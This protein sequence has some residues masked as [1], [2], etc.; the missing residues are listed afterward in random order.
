MGPLDPGAA[1]GGGHW[2]R[3]SSCR[4]HLVSHSGSAGPPGPDGR[5]PAAHMIGNPL[6]DEERA[7]KFAGPSPHDVACPAALR[8][9]HRWYREAEFVTANMPAQAARNFFACIIA[10]AVRLHGGRCGAGMPGRRWREMP[11]DKTA[12]R[13][14]S[15]SPTG[16]LRRKSSRRDTSGSWQDL[17]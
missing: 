5:V 8:L 12:R 4:A 15:A 13:G 10:R 1:L 9:R 2:W 11:R 17:E 7:V 3:T 14:E 16:V 6:R